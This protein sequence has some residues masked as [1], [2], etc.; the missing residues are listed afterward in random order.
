MYDVQAEYKIND[1]YLERHS[2]GKELRTTRQIKFEMKC[3][4]LAK[5]MN[6]PYYWAVRL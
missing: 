1:Y 6:S 4:R 2:L 5:I 3:T